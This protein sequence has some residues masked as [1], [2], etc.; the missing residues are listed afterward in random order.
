MTDTDYHVNRA[1]FE[2]LKAKGMT[3]GLA[4]LIEGAMGPNDEAEISYEKD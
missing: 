1:T 4:G 3:Q 2:L